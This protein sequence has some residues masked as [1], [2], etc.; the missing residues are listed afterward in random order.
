MRRLLALVAQLD[1]VDTDEVVR[2]GLEHAW[3]G[4]LATVLEK[5]APDRIGNAASGPQR[6]L[7]VANERD[8]SLILKGKP[9]VI[10][11]TL[12]LI[13]KLDVPDES[14]NASQVIH[15]NHADAVAVA[16]LL[17]RARERG[18]PAAIPNRPTAI[19][20]AY[21][22]L[23]ALIVRADPGHHAGGAGHRR[24]ARRA[25]GA[26]AHRSRGGGNLPHQSQDPKASNWLAETAGAAGRRRSAPR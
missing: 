16:E 25:P 8:N 24:P 23:N 10:A 14:T 17:D 21:E 26:G 22:S 15:L 1:V 20:Q 19:I 12:R 3:V 4:T 5:I 7:M 18:H 6:V 11:E 13:D 2:R 9:H